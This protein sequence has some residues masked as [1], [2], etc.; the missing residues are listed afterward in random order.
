MTGYGRAEKTIGDKI[1]LV[2]IKSLNG[3]QFDLRMLTPSILKPYEIEIRNIINE[4]L[5][6]GSVE[7]L[8]NI[9]YNG[10]TKPVMVNTE[11]L[12]AYY[13]SVK[14]VATELN[15]SDDNLLSAIL[16]LPDVVTNATNSLTEDE[17]NE[18]QLLLKDAVN[19]L[20]KHRLNEGAALETELLQR[21]DNIEFHEK[22]ITQYEPNRRT[23][24]KENLQKLITE[25]VGKENYDANRLEQEL[26]YY[27]EKID[28]TE[29]QVRLANHINYFKEILQGKEK[30]KGKKLSF[31]LQEFGREINT[32]GSKANDADIQKLV[33]L[34]KDELEK[35]KEQVLN[36][37]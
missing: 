3:K 9:K 35:M 17:W 7:C 23:K 8:F 6:R 24:I 11:L 28:I 2:E 19:N 14:E 20:N 25:N 10:A 18:F 27:I 34:M 1:F 5:E 33:V 4:G 30:S 37:L 15:A 21:V 26:I 12:K 36:V 32:T 29:E 13:T 22:S 31:M 16:R